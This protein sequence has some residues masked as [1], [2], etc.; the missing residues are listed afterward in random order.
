[1]TRAVLVAILLLFSASSYAQKMVA[2]D[3]GGNVI[4]LLQEQCMASPWM[5]Q[6][7][8]A[9]L[10][11]EGKVFAA[12]WAVRGSDVVILDSAGDVYPIPAGMFKPEVGT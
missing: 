9:S 11:Y 2:R 10:V 1:M 3:S 12:C 6:W 5:K 8:T 4:T 7:K